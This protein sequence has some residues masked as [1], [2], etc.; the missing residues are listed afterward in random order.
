MAVREV[1]AAHA[2]EFG[3]D[4]FGLLIQCPD[5]FWQ[6]DDLPRSSRARTTPACS[7]QSPPI[8]WP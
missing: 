8:C 1:D 4:V 2:V 7:W 6:V 3:A 5:E